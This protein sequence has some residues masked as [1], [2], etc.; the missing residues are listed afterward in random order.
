MFVR[1]IVAL[2]DPIVALFFKL[3]CLYKTDPHTN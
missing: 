2:L 3:I 1:I